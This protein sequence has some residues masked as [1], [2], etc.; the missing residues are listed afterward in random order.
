MQSNRNNALSVELPAH[1]G[2]LR[3]LSERF[4]IPAS[5][6]IDFSANINPA[7]PPASTL[8]ALRDALNSPAMISSYP[9]LEEIEL[10]SSIAAH[11]GVDAE[12]I[13]VANG[14]V[15]LL[16]GALRARAV[17]RCLLPVP[18]FGE[19]RRTLERLGIAVTPHPLTP[20]TGFQ[21]DPNRLIAELAT[22]LFDAILLAN[23]QNPS[24]ALC[25]G[26]ILLAIIEAAARA[27][28]HV[29]L[30][31]AFIDYAPEHSLSKQAQRFKT[32]TVFCSVTKFYAL[33]GL[34]VAYAISHPQQNA[35]LERYLAPWLITTLASLGVCTAL[36]DTA[37]ASDTLANNRERKNRLA[38][39][40]QELGIH[41]Y[42][43]AANFLLLR[44]PADLSAQECWQSLILNHAIVLRNC[45][46]FEALAGG[47][48]RCAVRTES[49]NASLVAAL[50]NRL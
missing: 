40:L 49:E 16:E 1:G 4:G 43:S 27:N 10:K 26:S 13:A 19:Y 41:T 15:P 39:Q 47:H 9:D 7:G 50:C 11:T 14:F 46:T 44:L 34:R 36:R 25:E 28:V 42:P 32:L 5:Q 29:L 45:D 12:S 22:G 30:D 35:A 48:L 20:A 21:Y 2:Q 37:Y 3:N 6:L 24:G 33:P 18:S 17:R 8:A 23:P 38:A 31:E